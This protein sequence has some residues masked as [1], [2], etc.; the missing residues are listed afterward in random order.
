[1]ANSSNGKGTGAKPASD[2]GKLLRKPGT[3]KNVKDVAASGHAAAA[4]P[5]N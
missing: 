4:W 1:M 5:A 3:P 2:A